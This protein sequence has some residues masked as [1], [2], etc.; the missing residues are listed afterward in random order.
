MTP[1]LKNQ[2]KW[3]QITN[4][5]AV[6]TLRVAEL[7]LLRELKPVPIEYRHNQRH[8]YLLKGDRIS[9]LDLYT[10]I[11][12]VTFFWK[13]VEGQLYFYSCMMFLTL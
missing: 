4:N 2:V 11:F 8:I 10:F 12:Q 13:M 9:L 3:C 7:L 1:S 6:L 5:D